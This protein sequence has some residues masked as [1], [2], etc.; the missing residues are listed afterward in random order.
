M[1]SYLILLLLIALALAAARLAGL[2]G[3]YFTMAASALLVGA[4]GYAVQGRPGL[5]GSPRAGI[6]PQSPVSLVEARTAFIGQFT[7]SSH[8]LI[9]A[10]SFS[11]RGKTEE[12]VGLL[13]SATKAHPGDYTL[14]LGLGNA[15]ADHAHMLT[16]AARLA[17]DR[18]AALAPTS[19]APGY[20]LGL[21]LLRSGDQEGALAEWQDVLAKAPPNASWRPYVENGI[22]LIE[23]ARRAARSGG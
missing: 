23:N 13:R 22:M 5:E 1:T 14:W 4:A 16:P 8:W 12:A 20:F 17:F 2:R 10:D 15:L 6:A 11:A 18:S 19:A 3:S 9:I 21:A 7:P